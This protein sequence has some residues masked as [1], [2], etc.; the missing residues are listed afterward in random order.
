MS[1]MGKRLC[2]E[3]MGGKTLEEASTAHAKA[4]RLQGAWEAGETKGRPLWLKGREPR[5][6]SLEKRVEKEGAGPGGPSHEQ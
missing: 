6:M 3:R 4:L 2:W 5:R 1:A